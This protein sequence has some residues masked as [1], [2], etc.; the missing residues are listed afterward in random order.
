MTTSISHCQEIKGVSYPVSQPS[1]LLGS[2]A[3][4]ISSQPGKVIHLVSQSVSCGNNTVRLSGTCDVCVYT[5]LPLSKRM[6]SLSLACPP[7]LLCGCLSTWVPLCLH[8]STSFSLTHSLTFSSGSV[9]LCS[10]NVRRYTFSELKVGYS[11]LV[12]DSQCV[13]FIDL[14]IHSLNSL[15]VLQPSNI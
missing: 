7:S 4:S 11:T 5:L 3:A 14:L 9:W 2:A 1:R 6:C 12:C 15:Q 13:W 10:L 8:L